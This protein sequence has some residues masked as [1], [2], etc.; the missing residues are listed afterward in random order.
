MQIAKYEFTEGCRLQAGAKLDDA[1]AVG[2][3]LE[4]L[5]EK[6]KGELTPADVV[7]D[8]RNHNSPLHSFFEWDESAAAEQWR[9]Q[10]ARGLIRAVVAVIVDN[11]QPA[12]RMQAFVHVPES[13]AP[14]Y[15]ATDHAMSQERTRDM[16]LRQ[17]WKE[18][19]SWKKRYEHL[20]ELA[21]LFKAEDKVLKRV[22]QLRE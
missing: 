11:E 10:Q 13:G 5:R 6:C 1:D 9:L 4:M 14:H 22:P 15:R 19:R 3:H 20:E 21:D 12:R 2:Q 18:Y 17:A 16:I 8:A 7:S